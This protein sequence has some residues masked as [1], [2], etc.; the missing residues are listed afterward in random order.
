MHSGTVYD[1]EEKLSRSNIV[2]LMI[3]AK[4]SVFTVTF[5]KQVDDKYV[6]E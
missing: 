2:D 1:K 6:Q 4:E 5:H 3:N